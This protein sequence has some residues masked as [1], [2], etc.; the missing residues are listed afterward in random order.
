MDAFACQTIAYRTSQ[1]ALSSSYTSC[2]KMN[3]VLVLE[4]SFCK[5]FCCRLHDKTNTR[6]FYKKFIF[7]NTREEHVN[8]G[9][10][11]KEDVEVYFQERIQEMQVAERNA[12]KE[13]L[14]ATLHDRFTKLEKLEARNTEREQVEA[15]LCGHRI[16]L[17]EKLKET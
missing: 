5:V 7:S 16:E 12:K 6:R 14:E 17:E 10:N 3:C 1:S 2:H 15:T 8:K 9:E 4:V 13:H 11:S